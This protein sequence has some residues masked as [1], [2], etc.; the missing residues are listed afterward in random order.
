MRKIIFIIS[1][2]IF[3]LQ[4]FAQVEIT[5][6]VT[7]GSTG[8]PLPGVT[9]FLEGT[10]IGTITSIDGDYTIKAS[11][12]NDVIVFS[13]VGY[14]TQKVTIGTQSEINISL[15]EDVAELDEIVV[16]AFGIKREKKALGYAVQDVNGE[17]VSRTNPGNVVSALQGKVAGAQI[18]TSSGQL[19]ASSTIKIRGNKSF[20][21]SNQPLFVVDGTPI[22]NGISSARS[23][24]TY[25]DFGNAAMD[26]DPSNIESISILKGASASALYGSRAANGVVLI[27]TKKGSSK[28]GI[29]VEIS[30]SMAF[31]EVYL[32]PNYQNAYGQGRNGSEYE[33]QK[34]YSELTY[35]EFHDKREFRW[36]PDG[37]GYRMDWDESWGSRLDA[38]LMVAQMDSPIDEEGNVIPTAWVSRPD[39]VKK[40]YETG[41]SNINNIALTANSDKASGRLTIGY[42]DQSGTSPNTDQ[43]K[44]NIGIN[45]SFQLTE[46]LSFDVNTTYTNL[47]NDNLPQQGNSMRN[48]L[49]EFNSWFG[50][51]VDTKYLKEHYEDIVIYDGDPMSFNWMMAYPS[52]HPN[53]YWNAYKNTM[54]RKRNRVYGNTAINYNLFEGVDLTGRIGIDFFNEHRKYLYYQ[55]SRDWTDMYEF[56]TN[57]NFWEQYRLESEI[58]ADLLLKINRDITEDLNIF[59][60]IGSNY[61][62]SYD[63][64]STVNGANL[65]VPN[66]FSTSNFEGEPTVSNTKYKLATNSVFASANLGFKR[67]LFLDLTIRGDWSSTLPK[68][69]WNFWY[70]SANLGFIFT[71]GFGIESN[72]LSY[73]KLRAGYAVVG[74]GTSPYQL[75][76]VFYSIGT[77][78]NGV[79]LYG[80]QATLPTYNLLPEMTN[81][82][83]VGGEFKFFM[84]RLG[85]DITYYDAVTKNQ[86]LTVDIP[87]S[88][89][90]SGWK[91]NAGS[92]QNKGIELQLYGTIIESDNGFNWD[93]NL[94]WSTNRNTI[95]DLAEG[96]DELEIS[97][98]YRGTS[99]MAFPN[100]E[101]GALYGTTFER[102]ANDNIIVDK[103][104]MPN[105]AVDPEI[106]GYVN[107]DWIGGFRNTFSFKGLSLTALIDF[108]KGGDVLSMTKAVGQ[109]AGILQPTVEVGENGDIF[110]SAVDGN[111]NIR[112]TG[113]I[114]N[115]VYEEGAMVDLNGDGTTED[116]TGQPNQSIVSARDFWRN[117]RDWSE[118]TIVDGSFIKLREISLSYSIPKSLTTKIGLQNASVS[119]FGRNLALLYTHESNDAGIDPEVSS[120][121]T[122]GG[123]GLEMYQL[124]PARTIGLK[125]NVKL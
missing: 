122:V 95:V 104:G 74:N 106:L 81:S 4:L 114:V 101:W 47:S 100:E 123:T 69:N 90:Y 22:M 112:E 72:L 64:F 91:M 54:S 41:I 31:D 67:F 46:K 75:S 109:K 68:E 48:P 125:L 102:D 42:T 105:E 63:Q 44:F 52:Q 82:F 73:G 103:N 56:A 7:D 98:Y 15:Q 59:A 80:A 116:A 6:Q 94:N 83:E 108:R 92:I 85:F 62:M 117:S 93:A 13:F 113:I 57:G 9:V 23:S 18:V 96:L 50:R 24:D 107:P 61:R 71:D 99:L 115:G 28:Q 38:G 12:E 30:T 37:N 25:T 19:G 21:G 34:N 84:D 14:A 58:N 88:S 89:G 33:W 5:G 10:T 1:L 36:S 27:T 60:T 78:F 55:Y 76:P 97:Y 8:E 119:V 3:N 32:L 66:F 43:T 77:T 20:T 120:G 39:N 29:G 79:N 51:Q 45:S 121:G 86:L 49:V 65:V 124:P 110:R 35:Q 118:L 11:S 2:L 16:T 40:F 87:Y 70:P 53:P 17:E 111:G 26:I